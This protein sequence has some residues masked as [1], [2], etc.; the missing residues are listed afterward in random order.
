MMPDGSQRVV[1]ALGA[2][3]GAQRS[4]VTGQAREQLLNGGRP[5]GQAQ[6]LEPDGLVPERGSLDLQ[7]LGGE[8]PAGAGLVAGGG[9]EGQPFP[10]GVGL[11]VAGGAQDLV[12][13]VEVELDQ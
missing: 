10:A 3:Q 6:A 11:Q 8:G 7:P 12:R 9:A 1:D 2:N 4:Q 5:P 13:R